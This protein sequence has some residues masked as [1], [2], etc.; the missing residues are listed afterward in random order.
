MDLVKYNSICEEYKRL[1]K[2]LN[3]VHLQDV[4][5]Q[6]IVKY[7]AE[8]IPDSVIKCIVAYIHQWETKLKV[9]RI[10]WNKAYADYKQ[11]KETIISTSMNLDVS[12]TIVAK[13]FLLNLTDKS[14]VKLW[15]QDSSNIPDGK[16]T[17]MVSL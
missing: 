5:D 1:R 6:L 4:I 3:A 8:G 11:G 10:D 2:C 13:K 17:K 16:L 15:L 9:G 12:P 14:S 7:S